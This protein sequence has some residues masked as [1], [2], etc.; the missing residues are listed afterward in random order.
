MILACHESVIS[1]LCYFRG[2]VG[3]L[4]LRADLRV[5]HSS[6]MEEIGVRRPRLQ[7]GYSNP[8]VLQFVPQGLREGQPK[9]LRG[10]IEASKG[11]G[12]VPAIEDVNRIR[13][14][15]RASISRTTYFAR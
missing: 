1:L 4:A 2:V 7:R 3:V 11:V 9:R 6:A 8:A 12:M 15:P 13:P 5:I 14:A 10:P